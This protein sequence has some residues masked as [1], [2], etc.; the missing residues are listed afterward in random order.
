MFGAIIG[1]IAGSPYEF[2]R[3]RPDPGFTFFAPDAGWTDDTLMTLAVAAAVMDA[4]GVQDSGAAEIRQSMRRFAR[5]H[6]VQRGGF[7]GMFT[8]WLGS[9]HPRPY[10][11]F[12]NGAAMRVSPVGWLYP[13]LELTQQWAA[14]SA[15]VTHDHPEGIKGARSV[16]AAIFLA[17]TGGSKAVLE[18]HWTE[19]FGYD[20]EAARERIRIGCVDGVTCQETVPEAAVA[21]LDATSFDDAVR[22]AVLMGGDTDTR[23]AIAGSIA[24]AFWGIEPDLVDQ[25]KARLPAELAAVAERFERRV[26]NNRLA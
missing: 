11:S 19:G 26:R 13:T 15:S 10:G 3:T 21:F 17:R 18:R 1:D 4:D 9:P 25:A 6:H 12:G 2:S 7:G 20:L 14:I 24:E 22:R 16:A 5:A 23:G 8:S